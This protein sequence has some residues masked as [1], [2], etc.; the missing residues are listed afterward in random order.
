M[1]LFGNKSAKPA[2]RLEQLAAKPLRMVNVD[3]ETDENGAGRLRV[4][5]T[6]GRFKWLYSPPPGATKTFELD[7]LGVTVWRLCDGKNSIRQI[8]RKLSKQYNLNE[9]ETEQATIAFLRMLT[10]KGLIGVL[11]DES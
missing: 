1:G 8:I 7:A 3:L 9:R 4:P 2:D 11:R 5:L 6:P 10:R